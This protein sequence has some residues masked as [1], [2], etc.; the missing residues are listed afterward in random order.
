MAPLDAETERRIRQ[1]KAL[2]GAVLVADDDVL[3]AHVHIGVAEHKRAF[4]FQCSICGR[5]ERNNQDMEPLCTG[6]QWTDDHEPTVMTRQ[7]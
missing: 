3:N 6:P 5:V 2:G 1:F 7:P 4:V